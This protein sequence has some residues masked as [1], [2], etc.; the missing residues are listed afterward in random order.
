[1]RKAVL[2]L[3][4]IALTAPA[5]IALAD[6]GPAVYWD[7]QGVTTTI[8]N[9]CKIPNAFLAIER[10]PDGRARVEESASLTADQ[11]R[12]VDDMLN[13]FRILSRDDPRGTAAGHTKTL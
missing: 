6:D 10:E 1:M 8:E 9:N 3:A 13:S 4:L 12:C 7:P 11:L 2:S 5:G